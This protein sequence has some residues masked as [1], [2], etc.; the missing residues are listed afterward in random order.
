MTQKGTR[1]MVHGS[2]YLVISFLGRFDDYWW[3][4]RVSLGDMNYSSG[5]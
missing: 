4:S 3:A 2:E 5:S 1:K